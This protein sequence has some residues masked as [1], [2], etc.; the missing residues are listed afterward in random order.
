MCKTDTLN[1][2]PQRREDTTVH[3]EMH[4]LC[5]TLRLGDFV[6]MTATRPTLTPEMCPAACADRSERKAPCLNLEG[7]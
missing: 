4:F 1:F 5:A 6:A 2:Q 7:G 3:K